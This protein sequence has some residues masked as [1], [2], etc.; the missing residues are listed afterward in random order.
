MVI[1]P[2]LVYAKRIKQQNLL[3]KRKL[4][5]QKL[6][7]LKMRIQIVTA[8]AVHHVHPVV[9]VVR[10][11]NLYIRHIKCEVL[12]WK[13]VPKYKIK[14]ASIK[15]GMRCKPHE[16]RERRKDFHTQVMIIDQ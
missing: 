7:H 5:E 8:V 12:Q 14:A 2:N 6:I 9:P 16:V 13:K 3:V 4:I 1:A 11:Y 15:G 10:I